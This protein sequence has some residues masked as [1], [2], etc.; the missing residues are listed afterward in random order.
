MAVASGPA[1]TLGLETY[2][3]SVAPVLTPQAKNLTNVAG[4]ANVTARWLS[5]PDGVVSNP[6]EPVLPLAALNVTP[7]DPSLVL[8]G[9]GFRSGTYVDS[10]PLLP[11][12]GAPT[13]ELRGVHVPFISPVFYP[14]LARMSTPNYFGALA[15]SG[16]T[17]LLVTPAQHVVADLVAGTS[18][19]R[20]YTGVDVRLFYSANLSQA[21]L[22]D[23]PSIVS[24]DAEPNAGGVLFTAQ[25]TGD[26][27]AAIY[28]VWVTYTSDGANAW[29]SLDL[30][31]CVA[32][33]PAACGGTA[34]SRQW[35]GQLAVAPTNLRY[36][37]QAVSGVG[38]VALDDNRGGYY[39]LGGATPAATT[40]AL[41][42]PPTSA[43][44]GDT[45][46]I[47]TKLTFAG[48]PVAGKTVLV[49]IGG[50][51]QVG[52]T[53][54]DGGVTVNV[55]V[56][57]PPGTY[58]MTVSFAGDATFEASST[59]TTFTV[60]KAPSN[61]TALAPAGV[62]LTGTLGGKNEVLQQ[63]AVSFS[64]TGPGGSTTIWVTTDDLGRAML[65][66]PGLPAGNYTATQANYAGSAIY[67]GTSVALS[68]AFVVPKLNQSITF[69]PLV[70]KIFGDPDFAVFA[71]A[72]SGLGVSFGASG[73][74]TVVGSTVHLTGSGSCTITADQFG[75]ANTNAAPQVARTFSIIAAPTVVSLVRA[76]PSPTMADSV[77]YTATFSEAVTGV[78]T[79]NFA[80]ATSDVTSASVTSV[81]GAGTTWTVT[82][83]TGRG[84]GTLRLDVANGTGIVDAG[85]VALA[86]TP[87]TGETYDVDKGGTVV[88]GGSG[89]DGLPVASFGSGGYALFGDV[90][91]AAAWGLIAVLPD[92]RI[93][94]ASAIACDAQTNLCTLQLGQY[95]PTGALDASF[96]T[97]GRIVTSVT[98]V[99]PE[100][101][102]ISVNADGTFLVGG[103]LNNGTNDVPFVA[104]FTAA[105]TPDASFGT[106]GVTVLNSLPLFAAISGFAVDASGRGVIAGNTVPIPNQGVHTFVARLTSAGALDATFGSGGVATFSISPV[107]DQGRSVAIQ[108]DGKIVVGGRTRPTPGVLSSDLFLVLRVDGTGALDPTFGTNGVATTRI[109][110]TP[111]ANI[112]RKL[113]LQ[114]DGKIV[115][116]GNLLNLDGTAFAGCGIARFNGD[117]SID[118]GF[119]NG[120]QVFEP[121]LDQGCFGVSLQPDGKTVIVGDASNA[122]VSIAG[123]LRLLLDGSPD[124]TFGNNGGVGISSYGV[125]APVAVTPS[126][127]LLTTLAV[128]DPSDGVIKSYVV[129]LGSTLAGPWLS[130]S[131]SFDPLPDTS[132][133][134]LAFA[135]NPSTSSGLPLSLSA[136]GPCVLAGNMVQ[137]GAAGSC[138][139]TASQAGSA[140]YFA[141]SVSQT[142]TI[143]AANQ[144][145]TFG[146][147]P[148]G[149]TVGQPLVLVSATSS[150]PTGPPSAIPIQFTSLT[151]AICVTSGGLNG[152]LLTLLAPGQCTIAGNQSGDANYTAAPQATQNFT[153]GPAGA[154][155]SV[156]TVTNLNDR[157]AGSLRSAIASANATAPGPN[158]VNFAPGL[159]GTI[160]L[161]TGQIQISRS[162]VIQGPGADNLT[163]DG[164]ANSRIFSIFAT[165]PTCPALDGPDY[166]VLISGLRLTNAWR[167]TSNGA[168]A[169]F[170]EHSLAL[171]SVIVENSVARQG[172]GLYF[173]IQ[174]P[175]QTLT[176]TNS[177]FLNNVATPDVFPAGTAGQNGAGMRIAERCTTPQTTP[178]TVIISNSLFSGNLSQPTGTLTA[179]GG[180]FD[181]YSLADITIADSRIVANQVAAANPPVPGFGGTNYRAAGIH[182]TAKSLLIYRTEIADNA[183][184]D[185]SGS[186]TTRAGGLN[187]YQD[188]PT[189]QGPADAMA[190]RIVDSTISGNTVAATGGAMT[191]YGDVALE[192]DNT[193]VANN[194]A[195]PTRTGGIIMSTGATEP[196]SAGNATPPSLKL[197]SSILANNSSNG[198][199]VAS[200][201]TTIPS[202]GIN[203]SDSLI[204]KVC[205]TCNIVV[206]GPGSQ[207]GVDPLLAPLAFN[208]GTKRTHALLPGSPAIDTGNNAVGL[209]TDQRGHGFPRVSGST[210]DMGAYEASQAVPLAAGTYFDR[211][212]GLIGT[213]FLFDPV[214]VTGTLPSITVTGP[215]SWNGGNTFSCVRYQPQGRQPVVDGA[216][217]AYFTTATGNLVVVDTAAN[218]ID[219]T[220]AVGANPYAAVVNPGGTRVYVSNF[221]D[222]TVS[223]LDA[224]TNGVI[225]TVPVGAGPQGLAVN[226]SGTRVYVASFTAGTVSVIDG[227]TN[228]VITAIPVAAAVD[229]VVNHAA[230]RLY[231][232]DGAGVAIVDTATNLVTGSIPAGALSSFATIAISKDDTRLYAWSSGSASVAVIDT[233]T[234]SIVATI[235]IASPF[236]NDGIA[237]DPSGAAVYQ[238]NGGSVAEI[239]PTTNTI[240][241]SVP[242]GTV[243]S[244]VNGVAVTPDGERV[245]AATASGVRTFDTATETVTPI[246]TG[247]VRALGHFIGSGPTKA[248]ED[249]QDRSICWTLALPITGNYSA[250][251]IAGG[252]PFTGTSSLDATSQLAA[253]QITSLTPGADSVSV[254]WT[255][256]PEAGSF[257]VRVN[258]VPFTGIIDEKIVS[259][260]SRGA[261]FTGLGLISGANYQVTVFAFSEDLLTPDPFSGLFNIS[262]HSQ[263]FVAP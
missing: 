155:P 39:Q 135:V 229:V 150:N 236:G 199:D 58:Q 190:V 138:T 5:G 125:P 259:G 31:Q 36:V 26:P 62:T 255:A 4:G 178:V 24:R 171:D 116:V 148:S 49:T 245:Y 44:V 226:P 46:S 233:G 234:S 96:G 162:V 108:P 54:A 101:S 182:A 240:V 140:T 175:G 9:I 186:D 102:G 225:A 156:F 38:L 257:L 216:P 61:L 107:N 227:G 195:A 142:F 218:E 78:A 206:S 14:A 84:T 151:P 97:N 136:T 77:T 50:I 10:A 208:G 120:G 22:S 247:A 86:G 173:Q 2:D 260:T 181:S 262:V 90:P 242:L 147:A 122:D 203:A 211:V 187:L 15:G 220:V 170:T 144:T 166:V 63:E 207:V 139:I 137:V 165:D 250:Q 25:V 172:A 92:G 176:I 95:L 263:N 72:S 75:D 169:I 157:G 193:T 221:N 103:M 109:A 258:A 60:A 121:R 214:T 239:D 89:S 196:S 3:L 52:T 146:P 68:Q 183:V 40:D 198:G 1:Q 133:G 37:V 114:P 249:I 79:G 119:G 134:Q 80:V 209:N 81:S 100:L 167:T 191:V 76:V 179:N 41:V 159:T 66:P 13:T 29:T 141:I 163:I 88:Y 82:V 113:A 17:E 47:T 223:V 210:A 213:S 128:Q 35:A 219:T 177:Q 69:D 168:G 117:G 224:S 184:T 131:I 57:M 194:S 228:A 212:A 98:N 201:T 129:E 232:P 241:H 65:P 16:G 246:A 158:L 32:P 12:S 235:P 127:D 83:S 202:F 237:V 185:P 53:A 244:G 112:G 48:V 71:T 74:C 118:A 180:A 23:A 253:P 252:T 99:Y 154:P 248:F 20:K 164:N 261:T 21:A 91:I 67:A 256:P 18:T 42:S 231:V 33:L 56:G 126:G 73:A 110:G 55:P 188:D 64:V 254:G 174:Y 189:R 215:P 149:V 204:R 59:T 6:G 251:G 105:G 87:F 34:D 27:A 192:L 222:N 161:T 28:Q 85:N 94:G 243:G 145:I 153:V 7:N 238:S 123:F 111:G 230:T 70:D 205:S 152:A 130:Q 160:V 124:P 143:A 8:R 11:F 30:S 106:N 19:Q 43:T 93:L 51:T 197:V 115:L 45:V 217:F 132:Y 200:N 104:K